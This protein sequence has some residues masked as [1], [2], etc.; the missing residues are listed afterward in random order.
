MD[1]W[2]CRC[3][4][5]FRIFRKGFNRYF[6]VFTRAS[7]RV[8][9]PTTCLV[10]SLNSLFRGD[11]EFKDLTQWFR[12][13]LHCYSFFNNNLS[14]SSVSPFKD[15]KRPKIARAKLPGNWGTRRKRDERTSRDQKEFPAAILDPV[16]YFRCFSEGSSLKH[17]KS[18]LS[19]MILLEINN[20]IIE[21]TLRARLSG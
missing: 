5:H 15:S 17:K 1:T 13:S 20:R 7:L 4:L 11:R 3:G 16:K 18:S 10:P 12:F 19:K 21:E 6:T 8:D 2:H 9:I 14:L